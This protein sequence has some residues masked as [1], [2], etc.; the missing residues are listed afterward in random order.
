MAKYKDILC[1]SAERD[2]AIAPMA[3]GLVVYVIGFYLSFCHAAY[4][5]PK[6]WTDVAFRECWKFMLTRW[7]P[8]VWYWGV[9]VMSRNLLVAI[10]G[11]VASEPRVQLVYVCAVVT[12]VLA[13]TAVYQPWRAPPLNHYD[14]LSSIVLV[15][16]GILGLVT[17]SAC[18][19][20][21]RLCLLFRH[22]RAYADPPTIVI[23]KTRTKQG[24][25]GK[26]R[27][28]EGAYWAT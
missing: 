27:I 20:S 4:T 3:L 14:V 21:G 24:A 10:A 19:C 13:I 2:K 8:D 12:L 17:E 6:R 23:S 25:S 18:A 9:V 11:V 22:A 28:K 7:R 5:A 15:F 26:A 1:D 16:I